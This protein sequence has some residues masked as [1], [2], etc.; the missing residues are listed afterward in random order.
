MTLHRTVYS[1]E[2]LE[3]LAAAKH[4]AGQVPPAFPLAATV[5]VNPFLGQAGEERATAAARLARV[6]GVTP[7]RPRAEILAAIEAGEIVEADLAAA[8]EAAD[9]DPAE[10]RHAAAIAAPVPAPHPTVAELAAGASGIDWPS[11]VEER[12]SHWASAAFDEGQA[13]WP[14]PATGLFAGWRAY[15][16]HDLAP[17]LAGLDRFAA[18][19]AAL[20][21]C[22]RRTLGEAVTRLGI[23][24]GE[25]PVYF[26]RL[27][28]T[29]GGW[30]Q[31]ARGRDWLAAR[32]GGHG[33]ASMALL[34]ARLWW[35][36][37]LHE[38]HADAIAARWDAAKAAMAAPVAPTIEQQID[39]ALQDASDRAEERRLAATFAAPTAAPTGDERPAIQA[40]FCIDVRSEPFRR[41]LEAQGP[42]IETLGFAGFFGL[43]A[44]HRDIAS[45]VVEAR[46][47]VLLAPGL[48]TQAG[49]AGEADLALRLRRRATRAWGRFRQAAVSAFAF[50]EAAGPLYAGRIVADA[51]GRKAATTPP[52]APTAALGDE[53]RIATAAAVLRAMS[54]TEGFA[55]LVL[56]AGHGAHV[57]NAPHAS[58]LQCGAC[59]GHAGDV[60]ARLLAGLLNDAAVREGLR[61]RAI[62]IPDDTFFVAGLHDTV[63]DTVSLFED[64]V[65]EGQ[66]VAV[67]RLALALA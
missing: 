54:L 57:T 39:A 65:P 28:M 8:A 56:L 62:H 60:S 66:R 55:P 11:L 61:R 21:D 37:A 33:D 13:L 42:G 64:S 47:P 36:V 52:P 2:M 18:S 34:A 22:P 26:H 24:T 6:A 45:D 35:E 4:A 5:A 14:T 19:V 59:G 43:A 29:L 32:D 46:A 58:A 7:F 49:A 50:V 9:L 48:E 15:A 44:A 38:R 27:L 67:R 1:G 10:L 3:L 25:A 23:G 20:P 51:L 30:A 16:T 31:V 12:L 17:A 40:A 41:A 53:D 63:S